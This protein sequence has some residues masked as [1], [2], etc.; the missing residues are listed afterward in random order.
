M[1]RRCWNILNCLILIFM[2]V[3]Y[4]VDNHRSGWSHPDH[5]FICDP[6]SAFLFNSDSFQNFLFFSYPLINFRNKIILSSPVVSY[7]C[8]SLQLYRGADCGDEC[9]EKRKVGVNSYRKHNSQSFK[10]ALGSG[11]KGKNKYKNASHQ[12]GHC[13]GLHFLYVVLPHWGSVSA[14]SPLSYFYLGVNNC[15]IDYCF[16]VAPL[17]FL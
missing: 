5:N 8:L 2:L 15:L 13:R 14:C 16:I 4:G 1:R 6:E 7:T 10:H 12:T 3:L 17:L 9:E 11:P